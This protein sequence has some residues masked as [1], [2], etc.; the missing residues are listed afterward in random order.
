VPDEVTVTA[1][2]LAQPDPDLGTRTIATLADG[3]PLVTRKAAGEGQVVLFHVT[4]NAEWSTLPLSGLF[5]QMLERLAVSARGAAPPP[6]W[7]ARSGRRRR[8]WMGSAGWAMAGGWRRCRGPIG[9]AMAQAGS[10]RAAA[11]ALCRTATAALAL[12]VIGPKR[13]LAPTVWPQRIG[14]EGVAEN[15][16]RALKGALLAAALVALMVD[17]LATLWL[18]GRLRRG[19]A[20]AL[21]RGWR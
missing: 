11:G 9:A 14:V 19:M 6:I 3:T 7:T 17:I 13:V 2:V 15:R 16:E 12:N 20:A 1:Q 8:C 4:A 5:V 21:V 10:R 18:T